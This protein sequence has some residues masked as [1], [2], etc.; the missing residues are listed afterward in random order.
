MAV[1]CA[2]ADYLK[3]THRRK[4]K[5]KAVQAKNQWSYRSSQPNKSLQIKNTSPSLKAT[6]LA[7]CIVRAGQWQEP[8]LVPQGPAE[9]APLITMARPGQA[10]LLPGL[11]LTP[12]LKAGRRWHEAARESHEALL[13]LPFCS[14]A[15]TT[16]NVYLLSCLC[17]V[18]DV[19]CCKHLKT[20][21]L[22]SWSS[23][24]LLENEPRHTRHLWC[25]ATMT[26]VVFPWQLFPAPLNL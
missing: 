16:Q 4:P 23:L 11:C 15:V 18:P 7:Q 26:P 17:T 19:S 21:L 5:P 8:A 20:F 10:A 1:P 2:G 13:Q 22:N 25:T 24:S 12:G 14:K 3:N 6:P 9:E